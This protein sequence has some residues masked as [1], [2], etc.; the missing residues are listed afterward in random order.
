MHKPN[1]LMMNRHNNLKHKL[2]SMFLAQNYN[3][4]ESYCMRY[5]K[6]SNYNMW[7]KKHHILNKFMKLFQNNL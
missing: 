2:Q 6:Y 1:K 3:S 4:K 7:N 5:M